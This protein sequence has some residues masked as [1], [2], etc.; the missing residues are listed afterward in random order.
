MPHLIPGSAVVGS[1]VKIETHPVSYETDT[2]MYL[3]RNKYTNDPVGY[4][5]DEGMDKQGAI[6]YT[7]EK[8]DI[9]Y[10]QISARGTGPLQ[11]QGFG[12]GK[13]MVDVRKVQ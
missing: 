9:H 13:Y 4:G 7:V 12:I 6:L 10:I 3:Y 11:G 5:D 8:S 2:Y 1:M